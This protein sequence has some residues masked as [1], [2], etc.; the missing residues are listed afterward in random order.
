VPTK[1]H[2]VRLDAAER[3]GLDQLIRGGVAPARRL[4]RAR[5]LLKTDAGR[6]GPRWTDAQIAEAV[7]AS[8]RTVAR[9]RADFCAHGLEPTLARRRPDRV[10]RR[11]LDGR[12]EAML[13]EVACSPAPAGH[14]RWS[15]RLL[16]T[17]LVELEIV[18]GIAPETV[19]QTLKKTHSRHT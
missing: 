7:D 12:G 9:V 2:V 19:R 15:L 8:P 3:A 11:K 4:T 13:L 14:A 16:A 18:A 17:K 10:Y 6:T 1:Q 5:I